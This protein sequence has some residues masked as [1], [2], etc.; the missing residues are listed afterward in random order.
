MENLPN[1]DPNNLVVFYVVVTEKS[2]TTAAEKLCLTQPAVTYRIKSLEEYTRVKLIDVKRHKVTLTPAGEELYKYAQE[3]YRQLNSA[4]QLVK[5]LKESNLRV[6]I[7]SIFNSIVSPVLN[8][9]FEKKNSTIRLTLESGNAFEMV[10]N[11][12]D[13]KID[14]AV[15]PGFDYS[16]ENLKR[17]RISE[18]LQL[19]CFT[20]ADQVLEKACYDWHEL[21]KFPLVVGPSSSVIRRLI[22]DKFKS[23]GIEMNP[24]AAEVDHIEW[25]INL[26]EHGNGFSFAFLSH[27]EKQLRQNLLKI[28]PLKEN[29]YVTAEAVVS[30]TTY[31]NAVIDGFITMLKEAFKTTQA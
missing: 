3:I 27:I 6:G 7:A 10:Q 5:S 28:V 2:F 17:I 1:L 12:L 14:L 16:V 19:Y 23:E 8:S 18:P 4:D 21:N 11:V 24:P 25:C 30:P 15:V 20:G 9:L 13:S 26:V 31:I 29:L 22:N